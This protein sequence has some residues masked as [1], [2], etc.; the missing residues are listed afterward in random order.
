MIMAGFES[1][2][3]KFVLGFPDENRL[4]IPRKV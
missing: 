1:T 2:R 3:Q 4:S